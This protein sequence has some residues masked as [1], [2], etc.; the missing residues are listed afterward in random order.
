MVGH[1][2]R[3]H[4]R[5]HQVPN[6]LVVAGPEGLGVRRHAEL[7]EA[8]HVVRMHHLQ[9]R[10]VVAVVVGPVGP[11]GRLVR[12]QRLADRPVTDGVGMHLE[13]FAIQSRNRLCA[14]PE[15]S[16]TIGSE[17]SAMARPI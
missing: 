14:A 2:L 12:V 5:H 16:C 10:D 8:R 4:E 11:T 13:A 7:G 17:R 1:P 9:M 6:L 15:P 3:S